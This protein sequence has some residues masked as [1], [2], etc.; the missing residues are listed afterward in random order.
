MARI[1]TI[2]SVVHS[3]VRRCL[4]NEP[5]SKLASNHLGASIWPRLLGRVSLTMSFRPRLWS[6]SVRPYLFG[7]HA[8]IVYTMFPIRNWKTHQHI[9]TSALLVDPFSGHRVTSWCP[10]DLRLM[11][12]YSQKMALP[13]FASRIEETLG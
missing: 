1:T 10:T 12:P 8:S 5:S 9:C 4:L 13:P 3:N 2:E 6:H 11:L 7:D